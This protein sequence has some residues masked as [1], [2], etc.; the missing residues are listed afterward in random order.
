MS[1]VDPIKTLQT[2]VDLLREMVSSRSVALADA[3]R[4]N[5]EMHG[6]IGTILADLDMR[7]AELERKP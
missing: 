7:V 6:A 1:F 5:A 2:E 3:I 4:H